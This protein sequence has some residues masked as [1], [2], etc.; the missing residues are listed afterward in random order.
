MMWYLYSCCVKL[1]VRLRV[2]KQ[3]AKTSLSTDDV[4]ISYIGSVSLSL[5]KLEITVG[6]NS[7]KKSCFLVFCVEGGYS[8]NP[9][10]FKATEKG[11]RSKL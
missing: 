11:L 9:E 8:E 6:T 1:E 4:Y 5:Q 2:P 10:E 7:I 3:S